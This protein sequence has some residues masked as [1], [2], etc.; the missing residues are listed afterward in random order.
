MQPKTTTAAAFARAVER[1]LSKTR[2]IRDGNSENRATQDKTTKFLVGYSREMAKGTILNKL[3]LLE[4]RIPSSLHNCND[5][6]SALYSA[7]VKFRADSKTV[8]EKSCRI[9]WVG[10]DEQIDDSATAAFYREAL[11]EVIESSRDEELLAEWRSRNIDVHRH[12]PIRN[13]P[14]SH[15]PRIIKITLRTQELR[16]KLLA[17]LL[18]RFC[19]HAFRLYPARQSS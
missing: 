16:D 1:K 9:T 18:M 6:G 2:R 13:I 3:K 5:S 7:L 19:F 11:K 12:P 10:I 8:A 4:E 15:R 14:R 17:L